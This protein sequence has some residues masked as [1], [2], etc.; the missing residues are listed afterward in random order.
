MNKIIIPQI[1]ILA[2]PIG[3][4]KPSWLDKPTMQPKTYSVNNGLAVYSLDGKEVFLTIANNEFFKVMNDEFL[5]PTSV[6]VPLSNHR[7]TV[8]YGE[9]FGAS[10][11]FEKAFIALFKTAEIKTKNQLLN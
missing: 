4:G 3:G 8:P 9:T 2:L 10:T 1:G 7:P 5:K 6:T 11:Q